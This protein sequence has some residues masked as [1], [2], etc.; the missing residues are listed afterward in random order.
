MD[1]SI[2][3][4]RGTV[5]TQVQQTCV[6]TN[7]VFDVDLEFQFDTMLKAMAASGF[8][9]SSSGSSSGSA[10]LT[11]GELEALNAAAQLSDRNM[12]G[13][14][15]RKNKQTTVKTVKGGQQ[16]TNSVDMNELQKVLT[17]YE[18]TNSDIIEDETCFCTDGIVDVGEIVSQVF[19][20]KLDPYPK[21]PGSEAVRYTFTYEDE[22]WN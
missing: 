9:S 21:K 19:R 17:G 18:I 12:R 14:G 5:S 8:H 4:V 11:S 22:A 7:E 10:K 13:G 3:E 2:I 6:R 16:S 15:K 1:D 20:S